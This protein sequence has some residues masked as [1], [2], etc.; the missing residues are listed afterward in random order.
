[1]A[2]SQE[3][4][5]VRAVEVGAVVGGDR[6]GGCLGW[7]GAGT[8]LRQPLGLA[9]VGG[10]LFSHAITLYF[11][12]AIYLDLGLDLFRGKGQLTTPERVAAAQ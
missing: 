1:M 4:P 10:L 9:V 3:L 12:P 2:C 7:C 11:M 5:Q 8:E 6:P